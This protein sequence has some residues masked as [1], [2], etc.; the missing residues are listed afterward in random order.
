M[1][2]R[3]IT[4]RGQP[5]INEEEVAETAFYPGILLTYGTVGL[6]KQ[7][8]ASVKVGIL[9]ALER[10]EMGTGV[11]TA[12]ASGD[13]VK[14]GAFGPGMRAN[15]FVPSGQTLTKGDYL[16]CDNAGRF[17]AAASNT[18]L[19]RALQTISPTADTLVRVEFV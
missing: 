13:V 18:R 9:L 5:I 2:L 16:A 7:D 4:L 6:K 12:Y 1:A 17:V 14:A 8:T 11:S 10:D 19:A 15:V 3:V